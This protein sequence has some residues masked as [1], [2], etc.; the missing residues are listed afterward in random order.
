[1]KDVDKARFLDTPISKAGLFSNAVEGFAQQFS[2]AQKQT[3]VIEHI[4]PWRDAPSATVT[5]GNRPLSARRRGSPP[6][7]S[8]ATPPRAKSTSRPACRTSC[9]S[10]E[11]RVE[12]LMFHFISV[13]AGPCASGTHFLKERAISFSSGFSGPRADSVRCLLIL[14]HD[15]S[16]QRSKESAVWGCSASP[17]TSSQFKCLKAC[18]HNLP[19]Q[20]QF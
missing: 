17:R 10:A 6:A 8:R 2:V 1:M 4:L 20:D 14:T 16:C 9:R 18:T 11:G 15:P 3:E 12:N 13:A 19:I 7:S 5:P